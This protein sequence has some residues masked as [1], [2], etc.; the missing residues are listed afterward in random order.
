MVKLCVTSISTVLEPSTT[1]STTAALAGF[2]Y[3][4]ALETHGT[5]YFWRSRDNLGA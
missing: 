3:I 2:L 1:T 4:A 5:K